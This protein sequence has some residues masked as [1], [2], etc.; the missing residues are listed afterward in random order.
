M[1]PN[2]YKSLKK[3]ST[4]VLPHALYQWIAKHKK[5]QGKVFKD[6]YVTKLRHS[7]PGWIQEGNIK[8]FEHAIR[9]LPSDAP[10]L[11][12]GT[13]CGLSANIL[14]YYL[15]K[16]NRPNRLIT[17]DG[18]ELIEKDPNYAL[19]YVGF[20]DALATPAHIG[21]MPTTQVFPAA[22]RSVERA[23]E[24]GYRTAD[25]YSAGATKVGCSKMGD[26]VVERI[27]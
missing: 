26:L 5:T 9:N 25:I 14:S 1:N 16:N 20:A 2:T 12:I 6:E 24:D 3:L 11:E 4:Y 21:S 18:W 7:I 27:H 8:S 23:L 19:A 17:C 10:V 22:K 13:Y 15:R